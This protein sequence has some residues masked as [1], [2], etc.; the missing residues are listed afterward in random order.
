MSAHDYDACGVADIMPWRLLLILLFV[1]LGGL[2][3][4]VEMPSTFN[5][6]KLLVAAGS[7]SGDRA[8]AFSYRNQ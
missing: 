1:A 3:L 2:S 5:L 4:V 6:L 7:G 8:E